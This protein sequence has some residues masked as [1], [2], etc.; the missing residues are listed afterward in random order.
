MRGN[1]RIRGAALA[2]LALLAAAGPQARADNHAPFNGRTCGLDLTSTAQAPLTYDGTVTLGPWAVNKESDIT[3]TCTLQT[4]STYGDPAIGTWSYPY[5]GPSP[6]A[7][8]V[9]Q[10]V[11]GLYV[12]PSGAYYLCTHVAWTWSDGSSS[13]TTEPCQTVQVQPA[14]GLGLHLT[15]V[16][17]E[18]SH[19]QYLLNT[20]G[21]ITIYDQSGSGPQFAYTGVL[22]NRELWS[23]DEDASGAVTVT[24]TPVGSLKWGCHTMVVTTLTMNQGRAR[25]RGFCDDEVVSTIECSGL[26]GDRAVETFQI[27]IDEIRCVA[28]R[29]V[30]DVPPSASYAVICGEP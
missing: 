13:A 27:P 8:L 29:L 30:A 17:A 9:G 19:D 20:F 23:C 22:G 11:A 14:G 24:C 5:P 28:D 16:P 4:T 21:S 7:A 3:I 12:P 18:W 6:T 15:A 2:A 26:C 25:G 1:R 10:P